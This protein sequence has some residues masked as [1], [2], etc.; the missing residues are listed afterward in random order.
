MLAP[1]DPQT[2]RRLGR[3]D[4]LEPDP[5]QR[6][7]GD[8]A[9]RS[10]GQLHP[11]RRARARHGGAM[12]GLALHGGF[13][14]YGGTFLC[15]TD[16]MRPALRLSA[17][18]GIRVLYVMTHD[19]DRPGR[20]RSDPPAGRASRVF[21]GH[22]QSVRVPPLR[23]GRDDGVLR[24]RAPDHR[25]PQPDGPVAPN[26]PA[27]RTEPRKISGRRRRRCAGQEPRASAK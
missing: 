26:L 21:A 24:A 20:G 2:D 11:L 12:N 8:H 3:S 16:Y 22:A 6:A 18:M 9:P 5:D 25:W 19:F 15:F 13:I 7:E 23:R 1:G 4:R 27:S 17:L 14:P 10:L